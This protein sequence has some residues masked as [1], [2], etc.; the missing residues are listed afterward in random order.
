MN[1]VKNHQASMPSNLIL[2]LSK[3]T[4]LPLNLSISLSLSSYLPL[5]VD[6]LDT[7][8]LVATC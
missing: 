1:S 2:F 6:R 7:G 8:L 4:A 5:C 3:L